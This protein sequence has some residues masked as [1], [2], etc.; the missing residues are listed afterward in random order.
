VTRLVHL[1]DLHYGTVAPA[2]EA[3]LLRD[4][5]AV[6]PDVVAV[7]GDLTQRAR[8][9]EL[10]A[11]RDFLRR[12]SAPAL[13]VPGNHD[14]AP[15]YRPLARMTSDGLAAFRELIEPDEWPFLEVGRIALLGISTPRAFLPAGG[16][17]SREQLEFLRARFAP[18]ADTTCKALVAHHP[19][20]S[21][22]YGKHHKVVR[23]AD[24]AL[25][26]LDASRVDLLL[27][28]HFHVPFARGSHASTA[29]KGHTLV[30]QAGTALSDRTRGEANSYNVLEVDGE[31]IRVELRLW[32]GA[33]FR[34]GSVDLF[35]RD[36]GRWHRVGGRSAVDQ[37]G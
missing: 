8:R 14:L 20:L 15:L 23:R 5:E 33:R 3:G 18:V 12:L 22:T 26:E 16:R 32:D 7:S 13:V 37:L 36:D 1:S 28:G 4:L 31:E 25:L 9:H 29:L 30:V 11:A 19:F 2:L 27:A 35:R 21:P 24:R 10:L 34:E 6:R 17:V